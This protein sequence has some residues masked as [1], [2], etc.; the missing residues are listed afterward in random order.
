MA[1]DEVKARHTSNN[2]PGDAPYDARLIVVSEEPLNAETPL[3]EQSGLLTPTPLFYARNHFA[4]PALAS[5]SWR[6]RVGGAVE[7]PLTLTYDD[8]RALPA[9]TLTVTL[10]CAGNG[11]A[12][13]HPPAEGEPWKYAAVSTAAWTGVPLRTVLDLAGA[14]PQVVE[15]R[16]RGAD[17]G[18]VAAAQAHISF[19]RSLPIAEAT[20]DDVLLAYQMNGE[21]LPPRH[22]FPLRLVVPGWYGMAA[23]KWLT[24]I[25]A[26][27][28]PFTGFYQADRYIM[29]HP[30]RGDASARPLT[31]MGVRSLIVSPANQA[32]LP[33]NEPQIIRG[34]AWSGAAPVE[35]VEVSTDGG[36]A[37]EAAELLDAATP[38]AWRRWRLSWQ[39]KRRGSI[40]IRSRAFDAAGNTQPDEAEW[41]RLGYCNNAVQT[42]SVQLVM[43]DH[44]PT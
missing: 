30:E 6:L 23:V 33:A 41:N 20:N 37:W 15:V 16:F 14:H 26:S 36:V 8:L 22:G 32:T 2:A 24:E 39:P 13:L 35:R 5:D 34:L 31:T 38:Y 9:K 17:S 1:D 40:S 43:P 10:E 44:F 12:G 27:L 19:E 7:C 29:A 18:Y 4:I 25:T 28:E 42:I 21:P 11:R 3:A